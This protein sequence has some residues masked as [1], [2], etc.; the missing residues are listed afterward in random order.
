M[1]GMGVGWRSGSETLM[2]TCV[3]PIRQQSWCVVR[4]SLCTSISA[5]HGCRRKSAVRRRTVSSDQERQ[6]DAHAP[7]TE[8]PSIL[9]A[10][11]FG[12]SLVCVLNP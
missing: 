3:G 6:R 5:A 2:C 4:H 11:P 7:A 1:W 12:H 8:S 9:R 10:R